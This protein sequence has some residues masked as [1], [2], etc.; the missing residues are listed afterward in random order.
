[1]IWWLRAVVTSFLHN[2]LNSKQGKEKKL[3]LHHLATPAKPKHGQR[4]AGK[5]P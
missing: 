5:A 2:E 1:M 3:Q 4:L